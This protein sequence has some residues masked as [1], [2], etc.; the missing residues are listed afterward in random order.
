MLSACAVADAP[1][2]APAVRAYPPIGEPTFG[3]ACADRA[4]RCTCD[5][6]RD[7]GCHGV[8]VATVR[9]VDLS[10][11]VPR[12]IIAFARAPAVGGDLAGRFRVVQVDPEVTPLCSDVASYPPVIEGTWPTAATEQTLTVPIWP[13]VASWTNATPGHLACFVL[14]GADDG[15]GAD[16]DA[17][18]GDGW[19]W[20]QPAPVCFAR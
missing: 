6:D 8:Y 3:P 9:A 13:D 15:H 17:G 19:I 18:S 7:P 2:G 4:L 1:P 20:F 10:A 5:T 12:A 14:V 11:D 16:E